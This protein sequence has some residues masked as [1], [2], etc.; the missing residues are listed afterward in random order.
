[1]KIRNNNKRVSF[2]EDNI[3]RVCVE[4]PFL[5]DTERPTLWYNGLELQAFR[6]QVKAIRRS[7]L[8]LDETKDCYRGLE[9][10]V[11]RE[12]RVKRR[13][14]VR[15]VL[16]MQMEH[17]KRSI[18]DPT[19]LGALAAAESQAASERALIYALRDTAEAVQLY[20]ETAEID[21]KEVEARFWYHR[22]ASIAKPVREVAIARTA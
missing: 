15:Y 6:A 16:H 7:Q 21:P 13:E 4:Q 20:R 22:F 17:K 19:G 11:T 2:D 10:W 8:V 9:T 3:K 1:M 14:Y 5:Y 12:L 18:Q